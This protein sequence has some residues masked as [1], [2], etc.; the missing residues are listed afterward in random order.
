LASSTS[1]GLV[2]PYTEGSGVIY[3][4]SYTPTF[5]NTINIAASSP[6]VCNYVRIGNR[7]MVYGAGAIDCAAAANT[8]TELGISLPIAS[9][10]T[11]S[12]DLAGVG[13]RDAAAGVAS[14]QSAGLSAD[15]AND[16]AYFSFNS[17]DAGNMGIAFNFM[18]TIK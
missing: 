15:T 14:N 10:L 9:N 7:V 6:Y 3:A 5:T 12:T 18:Y 2:N 11:V 16:R 1:A 4:G 8:Y 17:S 13:W